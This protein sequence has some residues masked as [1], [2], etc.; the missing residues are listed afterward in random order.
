V[1]VATCCRSPWVLPVGPPNLSFQIDQNLPKDFENHYSEVLYHEYR[2]SSSTLCHCWGD[3]MA[4]A[5]DGVSGLWS[6]AHGT[7]RPD[8][9]SQIIIS[10]APLLS[11][12]TGS[13]YT[14][15]FSPPS[16]L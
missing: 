3:I 6:Q 14:N 5:Y 7:Y 11:R 12:D 15:N 13:V 2:L 10:K 1:D 4:G 16:K 8:A 9:H